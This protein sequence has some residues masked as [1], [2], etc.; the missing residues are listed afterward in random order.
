MTLPPEEQEAAKKRY[1]EA[2]NTLYKYMTVAGIVGMHRWVQAIV[3]AYVVLVYRT[4]GIQALERAAI[5]LEKIM[6][7]ARSTAK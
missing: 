2:F 4:G 3:S 1:D 6:D 5:D 7:A